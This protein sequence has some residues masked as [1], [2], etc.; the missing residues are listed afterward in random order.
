M[1]YSAALQKIELRL[2]PI[3]KIYQESF[4]WRR[5]IDLS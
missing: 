2:T 3:L 1:K 5:R 4:P